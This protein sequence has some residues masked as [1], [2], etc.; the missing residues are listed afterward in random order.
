MEHAPGGWREA[1]PPTLPIFPLPGVLLLPGGKLPLNI[2]EPR[3]LQM[4]EDAM[5][6][7]RMIGMVQ[8]QEAELRA[9]KPQ[10]YKVGCAGRIT[11]FSETG[12][13]RYLITLTGIIRFRIVEELSVTTGY[14]QVVA[15]YE[16]FGGDL[17]PP[18]A[19]ALDGARLL[20]ALRAYLSATG[21]PAD[22]DS[23]N[24]APLP[25]LVTSLAMICPFSASEKQALLEAPDAAERARTLVAL[26]EMAAID[27]AGRRGGDEDGGPPPMN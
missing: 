6:S 8:P 15:D 24:R 13:G 18:A 21:I 2:F 5:A 10:P 7:H 26:M 22:W 16:E 9:A 20:N 1:R 11:S 19:D 23:I 4:T 12:D 3:Y 17:E 14:R 27:A 25:T